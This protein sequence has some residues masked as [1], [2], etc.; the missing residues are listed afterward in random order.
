NPPPP[1]GRPRRRSRSP[2]RLPPA[3]PPPPAVR[4]HR[5]PARSRQRRGC[6]R[7]PAPLSSKCPRQGVRE[8]R[9]HDHAVWIIGVLRNTAEPPL[10]A[11]RPPKVLL[12]TAGGRGPTI[13]GDSDK[14]GSMSAVARTPGFS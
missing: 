14:D 5:R 7:S 10:G 12:L 8:N 9:R 6:R 2:D 11:R 3:A 13:P 4:R 1:R